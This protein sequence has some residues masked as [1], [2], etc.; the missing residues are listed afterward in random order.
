MSIKL[1]PSLPQTN[2]FPN[3]LRDYLQGVDR[4]LRD[5]YAQ[6]KNI[7]LL[8][9]A[10]TSSAAAPSG[11]S[12][13]DIHVRKDGANTRIYLNINGSWSAYTNP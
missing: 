7:N 3:D 5:A 6:I 12:D 9:T 1:P 11:G 4:F 13:G 8:D 10:I 2:A